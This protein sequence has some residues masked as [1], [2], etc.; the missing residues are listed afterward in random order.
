MA[1][2]TRSPNTA[3]TLRTPIAV[4]LMLTTWANAD[5]TATAP[6]GVTKVKD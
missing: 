5:T 2:A 1:A 6:I 4:T 3:K